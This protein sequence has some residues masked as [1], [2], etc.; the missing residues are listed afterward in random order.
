VLIEQNAIAAVDYAPGRIVVNEQ[1]QFFFNSP[2]DNFSFDRTERITPRFDVDW[3]LRDID[4]EVTVEIFLDPDGTPDGDEF[5]LFRST[6]QE[7]DRFTFNLPTNQFPAGT[8][9]IL[10]L[11]D[12]NVRESAFYAPGAIRLLSRY[13]GLVDLRNLGLAGSAVPGAIFQGF[14]PRDNNGSFVGAARDLDGDGLSDFIMLAQFGKPLYQFNL[15]RSGIGEAYLIY[16]RRQRFSGEVSVNSVGRLFRGDI[17]TG[18]AETPDPIRPSRGIRSFT[19]LSDWDQDSLRE[20][21]FGLPFTDSVAQQFLDTDGYFRSGCVVICSSSLL[22]PDFANPG[23]L[24]IPLGLVGTDTHGGPT[25]A[26]CPEGMYG[27][28]APPSG[29][30][31]GSTFYYRHL[32]QDPTVH[33]LIGCRISSNEFGDSFGEDISTGDFDSIIMS[34][35]NRD[36]SIGTLTQPLLVPVP[37]AGVIS[38]YY[39]AVRAP[40]Y[41]WDNVN[42][43]P[44]NGAVNYPG[45][46][47]HPA[48]DGIQHNGPYLYIVD[49]FRIFPG[50]GGVLLPASPGFA[51]DPDDSPDPCQLTFAGAVPNAATTTRY[52]STIPNG[53]LSGAKSVDDFDSDGLV[54]TVVGQPLANSGAGASYVIFGRLQA[55]V[56]GGELELGELGLPMNAL[57]PGQARIFDGIKIVGAP[58]SRLGQSQDS[59]GDFNGDG[60]PDVLI[61]SPLINN[62]RGGVAVLYGSR[63]LINLTE[64]EIA[65]EEIPDRELGV[66]FAGEAEEDLVGARV[67]GVG[68]IDGDGLTDIMIA[69]PGRSV[70]MDVDLDG[71][72]DIDRANCGAVYLIY[73]SSRLRG[74]LNLGDVGTEQLPG[75][76]FV[77]RN[78]GDQ[79]GAGIGEQG[80]R[81]VGISAAGDVDGDGNRDLLISSVGASPINR[82]GAGEVYLIYGRGEE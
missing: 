21:A 66:I 75:V 17:F 72:L 78:S 26:E 64:T 45:M 28:K 31:G 29:Q 65:F 4:S 76:V 82:T 53:R 81:A 68:D 61:G 42:A 71:Q 23:G 14:N 38:Q 9:R 36:P 1:T 69:A 67:A 8:Y 48:F 62:R 37:G 15:Q 49:D 18:A 79:L 19:V 11:V 20:F 70:R 44:G 56:M 41:P 34:A 30:G 57:P 58:G 5:L 6:N 63:T 80:D 32:S 51:I 77:G 59:A 47:D 46:P 24:V 52:W 55:L 25:T 60:L 22:R 43:P 39:C 7:G 3:Q 54:D 12:D 35:P 27:P 40:F 16:G 10:A 2:R 13:A 50:P 74:T 33:D 73:G